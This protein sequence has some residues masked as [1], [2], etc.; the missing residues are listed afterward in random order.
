MIGSLPEN[1][2][3]LESEEDDATGKGRY[4]SFSLLYYVCLVLVVLYSVVIERSAT[5]PLNGTSDPLMP[6]HCA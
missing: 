5:A 3:S 6:D 4:C 1:S 2:G